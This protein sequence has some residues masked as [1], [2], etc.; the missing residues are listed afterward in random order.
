ME[1]RNPKRA[2]YRLAAAVGG[3]LLT[4]VFVAV[5]IALMVGERQQATASVEPKPEWDVIETGESYRLPIA[6]ITPVAS[7]P[8]ARV[9]APY[10]PPPSYVSTA[11]VS[12]TEPREQPRPSPVVAAQ[13]NGWSGPV[14]I[15]NPAAFGPPEDGSLPP[16]PTPQFARTTTPEPRVA[17]RDSNGPTLVAP[18]ADWDE[19]LLV[20]DT[21]GPLPAEPT[22]IEPIVEPLARRLAAS[23]PKRPLRELA[24]SSGDELLSYTTS[25]ND[26][27]KR[28]ATDVQAGFQ[29][30]KS[31]AVYAARAKFVAVLRRIALAKDAEAGTTRHAEA[32]AEGLRTLD[33]AD[34]FVPRGDA[35]EAELDVASI[36]SSHGLRLVSNEAPVAP[37]EAITRYSRHSASKLAE[38]A[39]GEPAGSMALYGLGKTYARLEAQAGQST[40]GRKSLVMY[41]AAVDTHTENYLAANELGVRLARDG[42]YEQASQVLRKA[43][44]QPTAIATV[45]ANL[46]AIE[47][48]VG[49]PQAAVIAQNQSE[50]LAQQERATGEVSR[51]HGVQWVDPQV[52]RRAGPTGVIAQHQTA[53][54]QP[55][56]QQMTHQQM[57]S[58]QAMPPQSMPPQYAPQPGYATAP[59]TPQQPGGWNGFMRTAKR[60]LGWSSPAPTQPSGAPRAP[61][62][63]P[64]GRVY[65]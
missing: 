9:P 65:R 35:L 33:D 17:R 19:P 5:T 38:A 42:R 44:S 41:R 31:G 6:E 60:T 50:Q 24:S 62:A 43:A 27:S 48:R 47:N 7:T 12:T 30:G 21:D 34:D 8:L 32:L 51:R 56:P 54:P 10:E 13:P 11:E 25:T 46:A 1:A 52:F 39:A 3:V 22:S 36:A 20:E 4:V 26:L 63:V 28:L 59:P 61:V 23:R 57:I 53:M 15:H 49:R 45:H 18:P 14:M 64:Q 2:A 16:I 40:A 29:L 37:H 58:Q 55:P